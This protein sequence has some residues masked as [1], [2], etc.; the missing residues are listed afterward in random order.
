MLT[1]AR[2]AQKVS[3]RGSLRLEATRRGPHSCRLSTGALRY[4]QI[5]SDNPGLNLALADPKATSRFV[6]TI[7][8]ASVAIEVSFAAPV[9][10]PFCQWCVK[11]KRQ[12]PLPEL[13]GN[14]R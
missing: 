13:L 10:I 11:G 2:S 7:A 8:D 5:G 1:T 12:N 9:A 6:Q 4:S 3:A 14:N